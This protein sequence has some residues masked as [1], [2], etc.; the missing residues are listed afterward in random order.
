MTVSKEE[1]SKGQEDVVG[2]RY[3]GGKPECRQQSLWIFSRNSTRSS[4]ESSLPVAYCWQE[5]AQ[6]ARPQDAYFCPTY[7]RRSYNMAYCMHARA[8]G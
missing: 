2:D 4:L 5:G 7:V 3:D 8:V 6:L 1:A